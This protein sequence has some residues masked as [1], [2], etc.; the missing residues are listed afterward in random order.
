MITGHGDDLY[1]YEGIKA[2]FSSNVY[3]NTHNEELIKY[4]AIQLAEKSAS[5]PEPEPYSLQ[6][7]L[8]EYHGVSPDSILV[9]NGATEAIYL[10]AHTL[11]GQEMSITQPTFSEYKSA[12][13]LF[14]STIRENA[15]IRWLCNPN[16]PT[17]QIQSEELKKGERLLV[18]DR[19]YE[20][21][22]R[23]SL[24]RHILDN[25]HIYIYSLTKRYRI[26]G[27]RLGYILANPQLIRHIS[28]KR[29][30]WS[31]NALAIEA[32]LW[33]TRKDFPESIDRAKLWQESDRLRDTLCKIPGVEVLNTDTHF[34]LLTTPM[35]ASELK[36]RLAREHHLLVRD[37]SNFE[38]LSPYHI[39]IATQRPEDND[40]LLS[41]LAVILS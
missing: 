33:I 41:A 9:T 15:P 25:S 18:I 6:R 13:D 14:G 7:Q 22:C 38:T 20:Y 5:Y 35:L 34:M 32:G 21:F 26:P 2:N 1:K 37:A 31:V 8:A 24:P 3:I 39:R 27:I 29:Q 16:N 28:E 23:K 12:S 4:L 19:S 11:M 30:P 10:I 36:E 17:G 40:A